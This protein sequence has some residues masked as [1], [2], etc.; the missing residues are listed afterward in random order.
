[1]QS[2]LLNQVLIHNRASTIQDFWAS[3]GTDISAYNDRY[4]QNVYI[5]TYFSK[6]KNI[7]TLMYFRALFGMLGK[8]HVIVLLI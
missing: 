6:L 1:M 4:T 2:W 3:I 8:R 5:N 7:F